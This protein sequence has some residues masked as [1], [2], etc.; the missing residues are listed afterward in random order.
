MLPYLFS[1]T[2]A[3]KA[4]TDSATIESI[5]LHF[6][7]YKV[8]TTSPIESRILTLMPVFLLCIFTATS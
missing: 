4:I 7:Y 3:L 6:G 2:N 1:K 5:I 8:A